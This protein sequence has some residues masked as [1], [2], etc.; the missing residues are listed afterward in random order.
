LIEARLRRSNEVLRQLNAS[1]KRGRASDFSSYNGFGT[2]LLDYRPQGDG[3]YEVTRWMVALFLPLLP[4]SAMRIRPV[5]REWSH[6]RDSES[7]YVLGPVP[8]RPAR[9]LRT[10]LLAALGLFPIVA[11]SLNSSYVNRT[12]GG[13][14]AALAMV[15][16][17]VWAAYIILVRLKNEGRAYKGPAV[18]SEDRRAQAGN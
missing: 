14:L 2:M 10:Y 15:A 1:L 6:A 12:L 17:V 5:G 18:K 3:T 4:L 16:S 11:G 13:P 8:L 7:F 9:V